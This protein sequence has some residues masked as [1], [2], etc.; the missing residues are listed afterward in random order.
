MN[1]FLQ[2]INMKKLLISIMLLMT[3]MSSY[4]SEDQEMQ[5][6]D[7]ELAQMLA[8]IALYPDS[9]LTHILIASTYPLEVVEAERWL[10]KQGTL[11]KEALESESEALPWEAS[12]KALLAF[13]SVISKLNEDLTWM[14][15]LGDAFL[16]DEA[17]VL[18]TIQVLR[19]QAEEA[20][21]LATMDNVQIVKEKTTIIIEPAEP[22]V[23]YVPYY[24]TRVVYGRWGW[25]HYPPIYWNTPRYYGYN[26][27]PFYWNTGISIGF[28]F[29]FSRFHWHDRYIVVDHRYARNPHSR[30]RVSTSS[31]AKRWY[32]KPSHRKGVAYRTTHLKRKY[33][34][35]R[36]VVPATRKVSTSTR[37]TTVKSINN[38]R[39]VTHKSVSKHERKNSNTTVVKRNRVE[40]PRH[41][42]FK[43]KLQER[44]S[45]QRV[46]TQTQVV[47]HQPVR[48]KTNNG[49]QD[50]KAKSNT[51]VTSQK[52]YTTKS[53][54]QKMV[55][56]KKYEVKERKTYSQ[57]KAQVQRQRVSHSSQN[58]NRS[59]V[60]EH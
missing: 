11:S 25:S 46:K 7:A 60:K 36:P 27:G 8:P 30:K 13:P 16:Q 9:L 56:P 14:Q 48:L 57:P 12:V 17:N 52:T 33:S 28:G 44:P 5:F 55:T 24:D 40:E 2:K 58:K 42:V 26:R 23:I 10:T 51:T 29:S 47:K 21:S 35:S 45:I 20:G 34:S 43:E 37:V 15:N 3:S 54:T 39:K 31:P 32:H 6:S 53:N 1:T 41:K 49:I 59:R 19:Q 50:Y 38:E 4:S 22:E 18:E